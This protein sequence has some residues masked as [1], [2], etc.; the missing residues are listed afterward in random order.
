MTV[1]GLQGVAITQSKHLNNVALKW[2]R[3]L[4]EDPPGCPM[5]VGANLLTQEVWNVGVMFRHEGQTMGFDFMEGQMQ[6]WSW[7]QMLA[8]MP[9]ETQLRVVGDG[10]T[11][12][13]VEYEVGSYDHK[14]HFAANKGQGPAIPAGTQA[15]VWDFVAT[16]LGGTR[17]AFHPDYKTGKCGLR[18]LPAQ[19]PT[20]PPYS[21]KGGSWGRGTYRW[22]KSTAYPH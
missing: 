22:Y 2:F 3:Q 5:R 14:R 15:P 21:G 4:L 8:A 16:Q 12:L 17:V 9:Y 11:A 1:A 20:E 6:P 19:A 13:A 18:V 10:L 7:R